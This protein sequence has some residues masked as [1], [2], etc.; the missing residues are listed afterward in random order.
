[1]LRTGGTTFFMFSLPASS[2]RSAYATR[3]SE[4][5]A[6]SE[7]SAIQ[8][9]MC[10][11][12]CILERRQ[13]LRAADLE[14]AD[15]RA[16]RREQVELRLQLVLV[17]LVVVVVVGRRL[18]PLGR[19]LAVLLQ[20]LLHQADPRV[21]RGG[22]EDAEGR[23]ALEAQHVVEDVERSHPRRPPRAQV[24]RRRQRL[25]QRAEELARARP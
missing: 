21:E 24:E 17:R 19:P 11:I 23:L 12:S 9:L 16:R 22:L 3:A 13:R 15:A 5:W 25:H 20:L 8:P 10:G 18:P 6:S 2:M 4:R 1:M 14:A 7:S